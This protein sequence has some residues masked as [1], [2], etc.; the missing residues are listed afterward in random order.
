MFISD[1]L[2]SALFGYGDPRIDPAVSVMRSPSGD[3]EG[4]E[5]Y[6]LIRGDQLVRVCLD[7]GERD[8]RVMIDGE[9]MDIQEGQQTLVQKLGLLSKE[10]LYVLR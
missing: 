6:T 3:Q 9:V 1:I 4:W 5:E 2:T 10:P 7:P 8:L